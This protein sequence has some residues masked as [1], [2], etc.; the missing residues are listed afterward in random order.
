[1]LPPSNAMSRS[2]VHGS[3]GVPGRKT[4]SVAWRPEST[5]EQRR[6][7]S[8]LPVVEST[9][10][11]VFGLQIGQLIV[12]QEINL[13]AAL[14]AERQETDPPPCTCPTSPRDR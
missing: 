13:P 3:I 2:L 12:H 11:P 1:M 6:A 7:E 14:L 4:S 8:R 10:L 5:F 9:G